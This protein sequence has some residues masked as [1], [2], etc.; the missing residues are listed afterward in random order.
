MQGLKEGISK[1]I[2]ELKGYGLHGG[3][4]MDQRKKKGLISKQG[5]QNLPYLASLCEALWIQG[6]AG[7]MSV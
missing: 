6:V 2:E 1:L 7:L 5:A 4:V 3:H